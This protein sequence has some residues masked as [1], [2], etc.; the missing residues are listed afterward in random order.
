MKIK[1][2]LDQE[3][4]SC[5]VYHLL[6]MPDG[7][8]QPGATGSA[9]VALLRDDKIDDLRRLYMLLSRVPSTLDSLRECIGEYTRQS[10]L[11]IIQQLLLS[12]STSTTSAAAASSLS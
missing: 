9:C 10:G 11:T 3:L 4:I 6:D 1:A 8:L 5:H 2:V 12:S 7:T